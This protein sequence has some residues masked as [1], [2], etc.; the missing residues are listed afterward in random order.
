MS[1]G[2]SPAERSECLRAGM[3]EFIAKPIQLDRLYA[4]LD[5][6]LGQSE[7]PAGPQRRRKACSRPS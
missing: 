4:V 7:A 3:D 6:Y 5:R 1:A 2:L